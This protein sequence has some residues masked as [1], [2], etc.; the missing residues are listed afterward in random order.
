[1]VTLRRRPLV[2]V[3][4][5]GDIRPGRTF[6][7]EV[8]IDAKSSVPVDW[9]DTALECKEVVTFGSGKSTMRVPHSHL[10]LVARLMDE[11]T[12]PA[13][14]NVLRCEF[15]LPPE[16]PPTYRGTRVTCGY[17]LSVH[18]SIPWWPDRE[19]EFDIVAGPRKN[20]PPDDAP[21]MYGTHPEGPKG[22]DLAIECSLDR[23]VIEP[24]GEIRG[25]VALTNL[26]SRR[27]QQLS[28]AL[29]SLETIR[30]DGRRKEVHEAERFV[31]QQSVP[32]GTADGEPLPFRMRIPDSVSPSWRS[33][34]WDLDWYL[35]VEAHVSWSRNAKLTVPVTLVP[36]GVA[37]AKTL[38][39]P[40]AIGSER[41]SAL[42]SKVAREVGWEL[43]EDVLRGDVGDVRVTI[44]RDHRGG[45]GIVLLAELLYPSLHL[46]LDGGERRGFRRVLGGGVSV[47]NPAWERRHYL[48]GRE[49][50]QM[51]AFAR[52]LGEALARVELAD[53]DDEHA[54]LLAREAGL[55][56]GPLRDFVHRAI[57]VA[58]L[59]GVGRGRIPAPA[60]MRDAVKAWTAL[61]RRLG[62][63]L[64][65]SRMGVVGRFEGDAVEVATAWG[66]EPEPT[67]TVLS[68]TLGDVPRA[69][70]QVRWEAGQFTAG[71]RE[72]LPEPCRD[73]LE[74]LLHGAL[75][76]HVTDREIRLTLPAPATSTGTLLEALSLLRAFSVGLRTG[77]GPYR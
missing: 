26:A 42:W 73:L 58:R 31:L 16:L 11:G 9:V 29:V 7:A 22:N 51:E 57:E 67:A 20:A 70:Q 54:V 45:E 1:M 72:G 18:V 44:R 27:V 33:A 21:A 52:A 6:V 76:F 13:G 69:E 4:I 38:R 5:P 36:R 63:E 39:A 59:I 56:L 48:A 17:T 41:V 30:R 35:E 62:G 15:S 64:E 10:R 77:L 2:S 74:P 28:V 25:M 23:R 53:I 34:S 19:G 40:P 61:A 71:G 24:G 66:L 43:D 3:R 65:L 46:G 49:P 75:A 47:G 37:K 12:L 14:K 60:R 8:T 32:V 55:T 68:L 50:A